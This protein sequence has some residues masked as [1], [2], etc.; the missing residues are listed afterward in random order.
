MPIY[1]FYEP[2]GWELNS[3]DNA[4]RTPYDKH[5]FMSSLFVAIVLQSLTWRE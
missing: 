3:A 2:A 5:S 1:S 4:S